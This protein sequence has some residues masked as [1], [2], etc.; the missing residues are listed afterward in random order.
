M[1]R[2]LMHLVA[3]DNPGASIARAAATKWE[4]LSPM[5]TIEPRFR[6]ADYEKFHF[7]YLQ[8]AAAMTHMHGAQK[9][10]IRG[11]LDA[12]R[13]SNE[14]AAAEIGS[15]LRLMQDF[16]SA[17]IQFSLKPARRPATRSR[18]RH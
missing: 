17:F 13:D 9:A 12:A 10:I 6:K 7:A 14:M 18:K 1:P 11:D 5:A 3:N 2:R 8:L 4:E 15:G 16:Y